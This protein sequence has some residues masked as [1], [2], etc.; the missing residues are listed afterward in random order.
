M[1]APRRTLGFTLLEM[2]IV[3]TICLAMMVLVV[4]IFQVS[5]R[6][7]KIVEQK[8]AV[9]EAAR[10]ILDTME[11]EI[12]QAVMNEKGENF[13]LK[14]TSWDDTDAFT[15][16]GTTGM[17]SQSR[18]QADALCFMKRQAGSR[19]SA[20]ATWAGMNYP[21]A[22][23]YGDPD[24]WVGGLFDPLMFRNGALDWDGSSGV[25]IQ[26]ASRGAQLADVSAIEAL[27]FFGGRGPGGTYYMK[28]GQR[29]DT[30]LD[31]T[32][33]LLAPGRECLAQLAS[34]NGNNQKGAAV[35]NLYDLDIAYWDD[36]EAKFKDPPG[37]TAIYFAPPPKA[38]RLT[39]NVCDFDKRTHATFCRIVRIPIGT[40]MGVVQDTMDNDFL[41]PYPYNRTKNLK[42]LDASAKSI[43]P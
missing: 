38:L 42:L 28:N 43:Y 9:Y 25:W 19:Y 35:G 29:I 32:E 18:R 26:R 40:G 39:I 7:V 11:L 41:D 33:S 17:Y 4:P 6:T 14:S 20:S 10:N 34:G 21:L 15:A 2:M 13:A 23:P 36:A 27:F 16:A 30:V 31:E 37:D 22:E 5:T 12:H 3:I 8:L 24:V 1:N